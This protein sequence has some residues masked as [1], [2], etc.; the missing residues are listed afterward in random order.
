[1]PNQEAKARFIKSSRKRRLVAFMIDH[2][3]IIFLMVS[4]AFIGLGSDFMNGNNPSEAMT[5]GLILMILSFILYFGKDSFKGISAGKWTMGIMVRDE[6]DPN[7][8][9]SL[10]RL[11]LRN[12]FILIWPIELIVLTMNSQKKRLGDKV[13]KTIVVKNPHKPT[14]F[15]RISTL[16][17]TGIV[18][19]MIMISTAG[20]A[21]KNSD[22]YKVAIKEIEK[23]KEILN[24]TGGIKGYGMMP[25]G[26]IRL[27]D[28]QG[29]AQ[30]EIEVLGQTKDLDLRVYLEKAP[31]EHWELIQI[32]K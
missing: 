26:E 23:N 32:Q 5:K 9:P 24:E 11:F 13:A 7:E 29:R 17:G 3:V 22:A 30:F 25:T 21:I 31:N 20:H 12:L 14:R 6:N 15:T 4:I 27:S 2:C 19:F 10:G 16:I 8:I 1:M 28:G 18:L